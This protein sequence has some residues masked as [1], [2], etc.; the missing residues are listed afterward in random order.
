MTKQEAIQEL[1]GIVESLPGRDLWQDAA[2]QAA[3]EVLEQPD[4]EPGRD[5]NAG[6]PHML[7]VRELATG[8]SVHSP[9]ALAKSCADIARAD[10]EVMLLIGYNCKNREI[11]R[12]IIF[13]GGQ[14]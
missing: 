10:Q 9:V 11:F 13:K 6:Q 2:I 14:S 1:L 3:R 7:C 5:A 4:Q 12:E 8:D